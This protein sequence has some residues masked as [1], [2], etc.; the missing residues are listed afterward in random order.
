M[1]GRWLHKRLYASSYQFR[2]ITDVLNQK[3]ELDITTRV[4]ENS[5]FGDG[6]TMRLLARVYHPQAALCLSD[7]S[8]HRFDQV[9]H[10]FSR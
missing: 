10:F 8:L 2:K 4:A 5:R 7:R 6:D 3:D 1:S 9:I